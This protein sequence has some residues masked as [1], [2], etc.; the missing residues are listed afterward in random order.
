MAFLCFFCLGEEAGS[1]AGDFGVWGAGHH[2]GLVLALLVSGQKRLK[3]V[4][5][6]AKFAARE[7]L[8]VSLA[9]VKRVSR[10]KAGVRHASD[11]THDKKTKCL[12]LNSLSRR[13]LREPLE[14]R[15]AQV[16][17]LHRSRHWSRLALPVLYLSYWRYV[18]SWLWEPWQR[19]WFSLCAA[20][21][22]RFAFILGEL[23]ERNE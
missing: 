9:C 7:S 2:D 15:V 1:P 11:Y 5:A 6:A 8:R 10:A 3:G 13:K 18:A 20:A 4:D 14:G 22:A 12:F 16:R 19:E 21:V 17:E 23:Q